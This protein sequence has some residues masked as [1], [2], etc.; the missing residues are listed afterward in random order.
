MLISLSAPAASPTTAGADG[1][2]PC[3]PVYP[4]HAVSLDML[5]LVS[6]LFVLAAPK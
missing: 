2:F 4:T 1:Y 3:S 5:E 6:T